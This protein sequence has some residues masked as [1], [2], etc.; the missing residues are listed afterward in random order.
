MNIKTEV[1]FE[2][3]GKEPFRGK[4][5]TIISFDLAEAMNEAVME[6]LVKGANDLRNRMIT[7]IQHSP[8]T[9]RIYKRGK[10]WHIASSSPNPP[11]SDIGN[12][13]ASFDMDASEKGVEVGSIITDPPYPF[14]LEKGTKKMKPR[15]FME[16][17]LDFIAP[18]L[19]TDIM[20]AI[21]DSIGG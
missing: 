5:E 21:L 3:S 16:P 15:P 13:L 14:Y 20:K 4:L 7:S 6:E 8:K 1:K 11:R 9:G 12:L 2:E 10:K 19:E 17:A 18:G